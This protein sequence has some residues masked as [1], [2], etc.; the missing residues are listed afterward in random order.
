MLVASKS[1]KQKK[2]NEKN[3]YLVAILKITDK[4]SRIRIR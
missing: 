2:L 3:I 1:N 4:N